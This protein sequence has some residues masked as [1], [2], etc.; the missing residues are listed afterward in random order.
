MKRAWSKI[1][2]YDNYSVSNDGLVRNDKYNHIKAQRLD[3]HGYPMTSIY[4]DGKAHTSRIH[5]L[6]A[7]A[8]I[9]NPENK[10]QVN[11]IDGNKQNNNV[12]NLEWVTCSENM[13]HAFTHGLWTPN[14][15]RGMLG[16]K[17]PNAGSHGKSI[18]VIETGEVLKILPNVLEH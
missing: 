13:I 14:I 11:H 7:E 5:R 1:K 2:N 18:R 12:N 8:F 3:K 16:K 9:D 17:N 4:Q 15:N 10:N 6:V